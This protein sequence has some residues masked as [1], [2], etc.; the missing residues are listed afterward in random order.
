MQGI[1]KVTLVLNTND[2]E[3]HELYRFVT[4]LSNGQKR[5]SSA[6]LRMLVDRA[7]QV[8]K[9][10]KENRIKLRSSEDGVIRHQIKG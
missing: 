7:Y 1:K 2:P 6:F 9:Q 5:N 4:F 3:Q 10:Q 8:Q